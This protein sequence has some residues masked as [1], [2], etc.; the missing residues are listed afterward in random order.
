LAFADADL[1]AAQVLLR[2]SDVPNRIACFLAQQASEKAL[3][4]VLVDQSVPFRKTH[5]LL[6]LAGL[7]PIPLQTV[8]ETVDLLLLQP[9]AV[10]GRYPG[11]LPDASAA[12]VVA[13]VDAA[14]EI[15]VAVERWLTAGAP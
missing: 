15:L 10:D 13:V 5:D 11:D 6:V 7:A 12:E 1:R 9:W 2:D 8:L 3:K 4:A 14:S